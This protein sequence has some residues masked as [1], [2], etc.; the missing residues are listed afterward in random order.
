MPVKP[1]M[2][3]AGAMRPSRG[4]MCPTEGR[5][6]LGDVM[7]GGVIKEMGERCNRL[8]I[9]LS[10]SEGESARTEKGQQLRENFFIRRAESTQRAD[11]STRT[12]EER[13]E[14][15]DQELVR[16]AGA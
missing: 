5:G 7:A 11:V 6:F 13:K 10:R 15:I 9:F 8:I 14:G 12:E 1:T 3:V 4:S 16:R 2:M